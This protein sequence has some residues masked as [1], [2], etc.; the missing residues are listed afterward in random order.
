MVGGKIT[1]DTISGQ[2]ILIIPPRTKSGDYFT[3]QEHGAP[4]LGDPSKRG[5]HIIRVVY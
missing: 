1:V 4:R 3:L 2:A 5:N